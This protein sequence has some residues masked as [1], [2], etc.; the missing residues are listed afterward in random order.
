[1]GKKKPLRQ[2]E[3]FQNKHDW[4]PFS[5]ESPLGASTMQMLTG[6][7]YS[8]EVAISGGLMDRDLRSQG[9]NP[10]LEDDAVRSPAKHLRN[11]QRGASWTPASRH[12][13]GGAIHMVDY[14]AE[15]SGGGREK[16]Y[17][18]AMYRSRYGMTGVSDSN[19]YK[20]PYH[21]ESRSPISKEIARQ[22]MSAYLSENPGAA[23]KLRAK[24]KKSPE[25]LDRH[26]FNDVTM[27]HQELPF[28]RRALAGNQSHIQNK[29]GSV[30]THRLAA[31]VDKDGNWWVFPT[32][33][34]MDGQLVEM[35]LRDAQRYAEQTGNR[36]GFGGDKR[37]AIGYSENGLIDHNNQGNV[38]MAD[39][40]HQPAAANHPPPTALRVLDEATGNQRAIAAAQPAI[41]IVHEEAIS[42]GARHAAEERHPAHPSAS[43]GPEDFDPKQGTA[44]AVL[45]AL[46]RKGSVA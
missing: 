27:Q 21:S 43:A 17:V 15:R 20:D 35:E 4:D 41:N 26:Y 10:L 8:P 31:E 36:I 45:Q 32:V 42:M 1:M 23:A 3:T 7:G 39:Q 24:M 13:G 16:K 12:M 22:R 14:D 40:G 28:V 5:G 19:K 37:A 29:D 6:M 33:V 11:V 25:W 44:F 34:E 2:E 30:S 9:Y 46:A 38:P 18:D